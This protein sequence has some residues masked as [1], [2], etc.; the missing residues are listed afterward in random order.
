MI[1][2]TKNPLVRQLVK[3][4]TSARQRRLKGRVL[5]VGARALRETLA[6]SATPLDTLLLPG[7]GAA[8]DGCSDSAVRDAMAEAGLDQGEDAVV[9][10]TV[11]AA[12]FADPRVLRQIAGVSSFAGP[13]GCV[14]L[15][16]A[17]CPEDPAPLR[18][19]LVLSGVTDPGNVGTLLRTALGLGWDAAFFLQPE[20]EPEPEPE[21]SQRRLNL[22]PPWH[23]PHCADPFGDKALRA[24]AGAAFALPLIHGSPATL[25]SLLYRHSLPLYVADLI[26]G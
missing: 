24:A 12:R 15:P 16:A 9:A 8:D 1:S 4:R 11:A 14:A 6:A 17:R 10:R 25:R 7:P 23:W 19:L 26:D 2:S 20:P 21:A 18:R 5:I 3:L 22:P 13:L